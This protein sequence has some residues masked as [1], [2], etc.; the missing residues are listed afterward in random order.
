MEALLAAVDKYCAG[1]PDLEGGLTA[2][3][4]ATAKGWGLRFTQRRLNQMIADGLVDTGWKTTRSVTGRRVRT[5]AY[6]LRG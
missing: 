1:D 4:I 6:I 3:E 5:P 2:Q